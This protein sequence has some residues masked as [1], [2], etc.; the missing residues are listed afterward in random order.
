MKIAEMIK[1]LIKEID[2]TENCVSQSPTY[3]HGNYWEEEMEYLKR[4]TPIG[5]LSETQ[6]KWIEQKAFKLY[7]GL[8]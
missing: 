6:F 8:V 7:F 3:N 2:Y 1:R 4:S 5:L